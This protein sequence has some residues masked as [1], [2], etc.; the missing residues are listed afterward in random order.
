V[1]E[2]T[3]FNLPEEKRQR[4]IEAA[5]DEFAEHPLRN[6]SIARIIE[7]AGIPR[8]SFYQYFTDIKDLYKYILFIIGS[9]KMEYMYEIIE[10]MNELE[11]FQLFRMLYQ[12]GIKFTNQH[13][14]LAAIG[15]SIMKEDKALISEIYG[16]LE[17][18]TYSIFEEILKRGQEKGEIDPQVDI[19]LAGNMMFT[20]N[21][22]MMDY[23]LSHTGWT[24]PLEDGSSYLD[25]VDKMLY[26]VENG[27]KKR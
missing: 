3:F 1:P 13:P 18:K 8:G 9:E 17:N 12:A 15:S 6:A 22:S 4:I 24:S 11:V 10:Q 26:I 20:L 5:V 23:Y 19:G 25:M 2:Q 7:K 14:K 16:E 21:L 27:I